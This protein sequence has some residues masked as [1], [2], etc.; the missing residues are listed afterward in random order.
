MVQNVVRASA[1]RFFIVLKM[2]DKSRK[3]VHTEN[4][5]NSNKDKTRVGFVSLFRA[6][7]AIIRK[8]M[9]VTRSRLNETQASRLALPSDRVQGLPN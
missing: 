8:M 5:F 3:T 1:M 2:E 4:G 7:P 6:N 9:K